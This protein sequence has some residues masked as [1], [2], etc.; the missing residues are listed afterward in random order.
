[1]WITDSNTLDIKWFNR[2][3]SHIHFIINFIVLITPGNLCRW[4][5][6]QFSP[7]GWKCQSARY[8]Q[9]LLIFSGDIVFW[10]LATL[11]RMRIMQVWG[12]LRSLSR[13]VDAVQGHW[14]FYKLLHREGCVQTNFL[15]L[16]VWTT[17]CRMALQFWRAECRPKAGVETGFEEDSKPERR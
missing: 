3:S 11:L 2:V 9:S 7:T 6:V 5:G 15:M 12:M 16:G 8:Y 14:T 13:S 17:Q 10:N 4:S 1:M